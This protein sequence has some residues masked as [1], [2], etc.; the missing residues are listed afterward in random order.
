[1]SGVVER[2]KDA[3]KQ[4]VTNLTDEERTL[5]AGFIVTPMWANEVT[6]EWEGLAVLTHCGFIRTRMKD[7]EL[8][9]HLTPMG[10]LTLERIGKARR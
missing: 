5:L 8:S 7:G 6:D 10:R 9:W 4:A 2:L 3:Q 1:M